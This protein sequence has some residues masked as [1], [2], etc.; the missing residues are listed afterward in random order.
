MIS[1]VTVS[2]TAKNKETRAQILYFNDLHGTLD[3]AERI[4]T[5]SDMFTAS[6]TPQIAQL[7][8]SAGDIFIGA[9]KKK[10]DLMVEFLNLLN[11]DGAIPGNH[12][13]DNGTIELSKRIEKFRTQFISSNIRMTQKNKLYDSVKTSKLVRSKIIEKNGEKYGIIGFLPFDF[14]R[15]VNK[16]AQKAF[17]G[18]SIDDF[19]KVKEDAKKEIEEFHKQGINKVIAISHM[20]YDVDMQ[21]AQSVSGIGIIIGGHTH[22]ELNGVK[23]G[24]NYFNSPS[25]DPVLITQAGKNG[26][27]YGMLDVVFDSSGKIKNAFNKLNETAQIPKSLLVKYFENV[28]L[29]KPQ[30]IGNVEKGFEQILESQISESPAASLVADSLRKKSG[31]QLA[32]TNT[33]GVKGDIKTG[34]LIDRDIHSAMP[35]F[36]KV[37]TYKLN[38]KDIINA[39][40]GSI[41]ATIHNQRVGNLQVSGL[42]YT[43]GKDKKVKDVFLENS[44]NTLSK[45]NSEKPSSDK[46]FTVAYDDYL[47]SG[48][49][50]V[51]MLNAP[52]KAIK[53]FDWNTTDATVEYIKSL[54]KPLSFVP[55]GRIKIE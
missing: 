1:N 25:G 44:D 27:Y 53:E 45:L 51:E 8:F 26:K 55:D 49:E 35:Y 22:T 6:A 2:I 34:T 14:M 31:A 16:T 54:N 29:G 12:E 18:V 23:P 37:K 47:E 20:G 30:V 42:R 10:N 4:A 39:L 43:I 28:Y 5:A 46:Y 21:L 36:N 11:P 33:A 48:P 3:G 32:I 38:E 52:E 13:F 7:K 19:N 9:G 24:V 41:Q 50:H 40:N 15:R 17:A